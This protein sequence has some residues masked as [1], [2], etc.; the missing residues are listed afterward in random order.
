MVQNTYGEVVRYSK[1]AGQDLENAPGGLIVSNSC[2]SQ[3]TPSVLMGAENAYCYQGPIAEKCLVDGTC[4]S[5]YVQWFGTKTTQRY[6]QVTQCYKD[7][8][9]G[10]TTPWTA[11]CNDRQCS[12]N[13]YAFVYPS[14]RNHN[15][16]LC[17]VYFSIPG[18]RAETLIHEMSHF[19][20][21]CR[22]CAA[23]G[24]CFSCCVVVSIRS[25]LMVAL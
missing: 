5:E 8:N 25:L 19:N 18:E 1:V 11:V 24:G 20:D 7:V 13:V 15:V 22:E 2:T 17:G 6:N 21:V 12:P 10:M 4:D 23:A 9:Y 14:D 3:Q 16:Y